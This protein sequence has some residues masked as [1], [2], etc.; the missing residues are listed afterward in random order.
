MSF[1]NLLTTVVTTT[2]SMK[3]WTPPLHHHPNRGK[4]FLDYCCLK[5]VPR[6]VTEINVSNKFEEKRLK[7]STFLTLKTR[8]SKNI[9]LPITI[10]TNLYLQSFRP[11]IFYLY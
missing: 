5:T 3:I 6:T 4:R 10:F 9:L 2:P 1:N 11:T 7:G 8:I